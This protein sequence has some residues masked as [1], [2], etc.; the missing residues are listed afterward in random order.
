[1][2]VIETIFLLLAGLLFLSVMGYPAV[3]LLLPKDLYDEYGH[4]IVL[5]SGYLLFCL[6]CFSLSGNFNVP[7]VLATQ[8]VFY[9]MLVFSL[10][11]FMYHARKSFQVEIIKE[12]LAQ[13]FMLCG[14]L[15][16]VLL[17]PFFTYGADTFLGAVNP[18]YFAGLIDHYF[19]LK[20]RSVS[21]FTRGTDTYFPIDYLA[22]SISPSAR[23]ASGMVGIGF[24]S[25][26][27]IPTRT[28]LTLSIAIF[29]FCL[30]LSVYFFTR[31]V[32]GLDGNTSKISAW[33][34]GVSGSIGL[35]YLYFYLGQ[36]SGLAAVPLVFAVGYL[37][38]KNPGI[39][40]M[41][42][43]TFLI[44]A[45]MITY[46]GM[47]PYA[48][49]PVVVFLIYQF[50]TRQMPV[51][52]FSKLFIGIILISI[53]INFAMLS[54]LAKM[55]M[56]WGNIVGQTLQGQYFLDFL[57][58]AFFPYFLGVSVYPFHSSWLFSHFGSS[59]S[60]VPHLIVLTLAL[61]VF[62]FISCSL[63]K[64]M[65]EV[66]DKGKVITVISAI[67][68]YAL[69]WWVYSFERQYGYA[70]FK[71][72]SWVQFILVP[73]AAYGI[74]IALKKRSS[75]F[76]SSN[77]IKWVFP[78]VIYVVFNI[79]TTIEYGMKGMGKEPL[80][81]SIINSYEMTGN[82]DYFTLNEDIKPF[83]KPD[84]S[85]GL[86]FVVSVQ[87][88]WISYYLNNFKLSLLS[89]D[90]IPGDDENLP[91][92]I[93]NTVIDYYGNVGLAKNI[94]FHGAQDSWYLTWN[95]PH[96][97][98]DIS[99]TDYKNPPVW[100]NETFRL[101]RADNTPD[102]LVTGRGFYRM[103][104]Y[105]D[106][107]SYWRP[108]RIRWTSQGGEFFLLRPSK[109][110]KPYRFIFDGKAGYGLEGPN[111]NV[112]NIELWINKTKFDEGKITNSSR[113]IS[114]PFYP[115]EGSN[116]IV[117][118][119]LETVKPL[120]RPLPLWNKDVPFDYRQLNLMVSN[121]RVVPEGDQSLTP[122]V[123]NCQFPLEGNQIQ[124]CAVSY[125]G[126]KVD[127]WFG[128]QAT[129]VIDKASKNLSKNII[130]KGFAAGNLGVVYPH[131]VEFTVNENTYTK[132]IKAA[133]N[134]LI[135]LPIDGVKENI[136]SVRMASLEKPPA[137]S[138]EMERS[139]E[140]TTQPYRLDSIS[141]N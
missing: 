45:L 70:V 26:F 36:N 71:M 80:L 28:A 91:D 2:H 128:G 108:K 62:I 22:G 68:I 87:N 13:I 95:E 119:V 132:S 107:I 30:P 54:S 74:S 123:E 78:A 49:A 5:P 64:W 12:K 9:S 124:R 17:W 125:N 16:L 79:V 134:F 103:E 118:K 127:R 122:K 41:V 46:L 116:K 37:L 83:V 57:T 29:M 73:I 27:G 92:V 42:F 94:F 112:R 77:N 38:V 67:V 10:G 76:W 66:G 98:K 20:G 53:V 139:G 101:F 113:F 106:E 63:I 69:V 34:A 21:D 136:V 93:N 130:L 7:A 114:K 11:V 100:E 115:E 60:V 88:Y 104:Y 89:H 135:E 35:S 58:E 32:F 6:W 102:F 99:M 25:V 52:K 75:K 18:D 105:D 65:K 140:T 8:I 85:I 47:L 137:R 126:I 24:E 19:L 59:A 50:A 55:V 40:L 44:N 84:E 129:L 48:G 131:Q 111:N 97:N 72:A 133:G 96:R 31:T 14:P 141:L 43:Y 56:G 3:K 120:K 109:P 51:F 117:L 33:L 110:N 138:G 1:M 15:I 81:G 23:F 90:N 4:I 86:N 39:G 82:R 121:V 61:G